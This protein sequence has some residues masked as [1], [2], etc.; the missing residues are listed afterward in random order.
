[1]E[2]KRNLEYPDIKGVYDADRLNAAGAIYTAPLTDREAEELAAKYRKEA[3]AAIAQF[4]A[5]ELAEAEEDYRHMGKP[6]YL[7]YMAELIEKLDAY[8]DLLVRA[9]DLS[10]ETLIK[11]DDDVYGML[12]CKLSTSS[13]MFI[14]NWEWE[15]R[16]TP[17][18][19]II[20]YEVRLH[21]RI[22]TNYGSRDP[23]RDGF[24]TPPPVGRVFAPE[25][26]LQ[27]RLVL[28]LV[29]VCT[30]AAARMRDLGARALA[31]K[32]LNLAKVAQTMSESFSLELGAKEEEAFIADFRAAALATCD[33]YRV[34]AIP[35]TE[36]VIAA[37]SSKEA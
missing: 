2:A 1:M 10:G 14:S 13:V 25:Y 5:R 36:D 23:V 28:R 9:D 30:L 6:H 4:K 7:Q 3:E 18:A 11:P 37:L 26:P 12:Y 19:I 8:R 20:L 17:R 32:W 33:E 34:E 35:E 24:C 16:L 29:E 27:Y 22:D 15:E 21:G 31:V